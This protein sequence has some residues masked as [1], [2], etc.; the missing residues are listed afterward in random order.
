[1]QSNDFEV[2]SFPVIQAMFG[3]TYLEIRQ[4]L[5]FKQPW[6]FENG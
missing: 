1:M 2:F 3:F 5:A 4:Q 6:I